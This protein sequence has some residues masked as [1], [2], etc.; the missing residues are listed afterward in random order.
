MP[1]EYDEDVRKSFRNTSIHPSAKICQICKSKVR[2]SE[3]FD[4]FCLCSLENHDKEHLKQSYI[5]IEGELPQF[6]M[7]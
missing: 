4:S 6:L 1:I 2:C 7:F 5:M 3:C